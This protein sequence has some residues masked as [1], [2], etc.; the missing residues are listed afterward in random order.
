MSKKLANIAYWLRVVGVKKLVM[1]N[2]M[3]KGGSYGLYI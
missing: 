3:A 2:R 1:A